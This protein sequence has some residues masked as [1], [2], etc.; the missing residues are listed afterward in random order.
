MSKDG[1]T[2]GR[3][4]FSKRHHSG[5]QWIRS[6]FLNSAAKQSSKKVFSLDEH[7]GDANGRNKVKNSL[8]VKPSV[9]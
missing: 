8:V 6:E 7:Q 9:V 3:D 1:G 5:Q 2:G 4:M